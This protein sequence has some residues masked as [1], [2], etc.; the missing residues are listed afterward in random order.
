MTGDVHASAER[1]ELPRVL[2]ACSGVGHV[3]RGFEAASEELAVMLEGAAQITL[4]RGGGPW[5]G[6]AGL[7]LP[8]VQR[9]GPTARRL[10]LANERAY[11]VE[12]RT[13]APAVYALARAGRFDVVHLH[14]PGLCNAIWHLRRRLGGA[15]SI[16]YTNGGSL[17]P[18]Y[19]GRPDLIQSV[20][21]VDAARLRAFGYAD[22]QVACVPHGLRPDAD[23]GAAAPRAF[24]DG[25][26]RAL[27]GVGTLN[28]ENKGFFTAVRAVAL[29]PGARLDLLGQRDGETA[30]VEA[31]GREL[32]PARFST[33]TVAPGEVALHLARADAFV[34][35]TH[36]EGFCIA[37]LEAMGAGLPCVVSDI[38]VLRWLVGDAAVLVPPDRPQAWA[39]AIA[40]LHAARRRELS[41]RARA[42]AASFH[43]PRLA[44]HYG[45]MYRQAIA[46]ARRRLVPAA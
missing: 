32:L 4:A 28:D 18:Q 29:L 33:A 40:G 6:G 34:L 44:P 1:P 46:A 31:L 15:F 25:P 42:R 11:L 22:W 36:Y 2:V 17:D 39:D 14:D 24:V 30:A 10:G 21:P 43:W 13:F 16:L 41:E 9:G 8:C 7:R 26:P 35:P 19:L 3:F 5:L 12:Q 27:I 23:A 20:T 37:V 38:P 45:A